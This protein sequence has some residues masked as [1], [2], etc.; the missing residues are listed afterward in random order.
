MELEPAA[1]PRHRNLAARGADHLGAAGQAALAR[2]DTPAAINLLERATALLPDDDR[3]R[4]S[5]L[6]E[7]GSALTEGGRLAE[8]ERVL[9]AA[10]EAAAGRDDAL[11]L[12]HATVARLFLRLQVS[13]ED[14]MREVREQF[15]PLL[16]TFT[17]A[18][19][20]IGLGRL[21]HL[22]GLVHWIEAQ[23]A[24]AD[25]AW[26]HA[27]EHFRRAGDERGWSD[28][29][30]WLASSAYTGPMHVDAAITRCESIRSQLGGHRRAQA[31]V[32][33]HLA[34]IRA[35]KGDVTAA[36]PLIAGSKAILSELGISMHTAVS[37]YEAFVALTSGD[38]AGAETT[39]RTGYERLTD[40]GERAL[41]ADT[42]AMLAQVLYQ[43]GRTEEAWAFTREAEDAASEDDL[44]AQVVWRGVRARLLAL[45]GRIPE[46]K[47]LSAHAVELAGHTDWLTA[48]ADALIVHAEVLRLAGEAEEVA[49]A[50][51]KA[52]ALYDRKGNMVGM[53]RARSLLAAQV[54]A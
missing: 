26:E 17:A 18:G 27:V 13:T 39:L 53:R 22:R 43:Q 23:S 42:A 37:H 48:H 9:D 12:A 52:I 8:A 2:D 35:M 11:T 14:G 44:S 34:A 40:M 49:R 21:W 15:D 30:S 10:V 24:K 4:G 36:R 20:D 46:A 25:T 1:R 6:P 50:I 41:L 31:L 54:L 47:R 7:L 32:L 28:A 5:L 51:Q 33:E 16:V 45:A 3:F 29:L 19:D 38:A